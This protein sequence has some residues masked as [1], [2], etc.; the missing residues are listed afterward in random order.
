MDYTIPRERPNKRWLDNIR[1]DCVEMELTIT[2]ATRLARDRSRWTIATGR[3][4]ERTDVVIA[5]ID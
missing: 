3:L 4:L 1:D 2:A 5:K